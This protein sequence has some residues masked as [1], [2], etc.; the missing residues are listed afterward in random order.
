MNKEIAFLL[1]KPDIFL[2]GLLS[3]F[4]DILVKEHFIF[5]DFFCG[6]LNSSQFD[7][8]YSCTFRWD[9]DDWFHNRKLYEFGPALGLAIGHNS[10]MF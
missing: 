1:C 10:L 9:V 2:R 4:I 5:Y 7:A 6:C 3:P 8:I